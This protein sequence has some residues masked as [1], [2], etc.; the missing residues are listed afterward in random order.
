MTKGELMH[1][2]FDNLLNQGIESIID[3]LFAPD[4]VVHGLVG[5]GAVHPNAL[6]DAMTAAAALSPS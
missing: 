2:W 5:I 6:A 4:M 3:E 1:A